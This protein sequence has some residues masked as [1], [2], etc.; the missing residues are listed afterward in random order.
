VQAPAPREMLSCRLTIRTWRKGANDGAQGCSYV[1]RWG[2]YK[3]NRIQ[4]P[5]SLDNA[6]IGQLP[7][8]SDTE[9]NVPNQQVFKSYSGL[10]C[11]SLDRSIGRTSHT[12]TTL[13]SRA[14]AWKHELDEPCMY[15]AGLIRLA[16]GIVECAIVERHRGS[17]REWWSTCRVLVAVT[18]FV[19]GSLEF[20]GK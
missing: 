7:I 17:C 12:N 8:I 15:V 11:C 4:T 2:L 5:E 18:R 3:P 9:A 14:M 20:R 13:L 1:C 10:A 19:D 6:S 16:G